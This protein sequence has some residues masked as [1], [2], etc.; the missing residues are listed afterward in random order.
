MVTTIHITSTGFNPQ[1]DVVL[2]G[3]AIS[4]INDDKVPHAVKAT[5]THAGLFTS[6]SIQ[7]N[8]Q[9]KYDFG[10]EGTFEYALIDLPKINGTIIVKAGGGMTSYST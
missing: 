3:T 4:W 7:P 8:S 10:T 9:F 2:P 6:D 5:G 1:L